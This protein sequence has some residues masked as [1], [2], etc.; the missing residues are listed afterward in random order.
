MDTTLIDQRTE[1]VRN[2]TL[3]EIAARMLTTSP[4]LIQEMA[5]CLSTS[6]KDSLQYWTQCG[7]TR[8]RL[9]NG[10]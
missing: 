7:A 6:T 2:E 5:S 4:T 3:K 1:Q 10:S 9:Q 8:D